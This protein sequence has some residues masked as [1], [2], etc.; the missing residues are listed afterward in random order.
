MAEEHH[1]K[2][3]DYQ[4]ILLDWQMPDMD[5]IETARQL[6]LRLGDD[7]PILLISA[8]DW[9]DIEEEARK[10]GVNGF[11]SKPLFKST[12]FHGLRPF[13]DM[14]QEPVLRTSEAAHDFAGKRILVAE[15]NDLNWE[16]A[17]E[18]LADL[19]LTLERAEDGKICE[20]FRM[21]R[22]DLILH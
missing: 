8:Y 20:K 13:L 5:G 9:S 17:E 2:R 7:V 18:L 6:R 4:I 15:D 16:I 11:I 14:P 21:D 3:T 12:L 19:G 1:K 22:T 10:A